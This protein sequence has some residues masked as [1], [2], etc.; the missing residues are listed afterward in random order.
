MSS[1]SDYSGQK[2]SNRK[3]TSLNPDEVVDDQGRRRF[4]GAFTGGFSAGY[5]NTVGSAE[6]F[7]PVEFMSSR[8]NRASSKQRSA[9][10]YMD[11]EDG[12]LGKK[13]STNEV[14]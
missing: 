2:H 14:S 6:G 9:F 3:A 1:S 5:F 10:D 11:T 7:K 13:L 4:H 12:L 8:G